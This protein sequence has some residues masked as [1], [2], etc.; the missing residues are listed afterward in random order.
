[1]LLFIK[2]GNFWR[3]GCGSFFEWMD[4]LVGALAGPGVTLLPFGTARFPLDTTQRNAWGWGR[5]RGGPQ[6]RALATPP[7][8]IYQKAAGN[9]GF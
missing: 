9:L 6:A 5:G 7:S 3:S 8:L 1:M 4:M 2:I